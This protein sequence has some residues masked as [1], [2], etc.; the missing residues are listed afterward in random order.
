MV[1]PPGS[2]LGP[3]ILG[4]SRDRSGC[5]SVEKSFLPLMAIKLPLP[6][7]KQ[8]FYNN[9]HDQNSQVYC[10]NDET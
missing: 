9:E 6:A 8:S 3:Q 5:G 1:V 4:E 2:I 10:P 7:R